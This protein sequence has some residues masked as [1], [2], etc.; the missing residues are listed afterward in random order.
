MKEK[1]EIP[2]KCQE[3]IGIR[4]VTI[5]LRDCFG[6]ISRVMRRQI[7]SPFE[8]YEPLAL[9]SEEYDVIGEM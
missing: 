5:S 4:L 1:G 2:Y 9:T 6:D 8:M 3:G 7:L